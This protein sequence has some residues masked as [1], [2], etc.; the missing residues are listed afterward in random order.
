MLQGTFAITFGLNK[1]KSEC[2]T[3]GKHLKAD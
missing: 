3:F 2:R 1:S